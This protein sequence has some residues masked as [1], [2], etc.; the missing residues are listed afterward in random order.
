MNLNIYDYDNGCNA[1]PSGIN[2]FIQFIKKE[3]E[4]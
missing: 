2:K 3:K 4:V 1:Q